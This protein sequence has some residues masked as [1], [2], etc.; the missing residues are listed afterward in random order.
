MLT[1]HVGIYKLKKVVFLPEEDA[2]RLL[3]S[4]LAV[5][6]QSLHDYADKAVSLAMI[7]LGWQIYADQQS[8]RR[9]VRSRVVMAFSYIGC[10]N[11]LRYWLPRLQAG[12]CRTLTCA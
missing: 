6:R 4:M 12:K 10:S 3:S 1:L 7:L 9:P 11:G 8:K 2:T 5:H